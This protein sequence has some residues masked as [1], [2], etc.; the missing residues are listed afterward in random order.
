MTVN[1]DYR[2]KKIRSV[3]T[4]S[5]SQFWTFIFVH[6]S[7]IKILF[8]FQKYV[9]L[10]NKLKKELKEIEWSSAI[11]NRMCQCAVTDLTDDAFRPASFTTRMIRTPSSCLLERRHSIRLRSF[12][13][14]CRIKSGTIS[15]FYTF[16]QLK[17]PF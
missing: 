16:S 4:F 7:K 3:R 6:F 12:A 17:R 1:F 10:Y 2:N 11:S 14:P 8:T 13:I 15:D 9:I 5:T